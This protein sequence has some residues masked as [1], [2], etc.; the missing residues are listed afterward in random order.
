MSFIGE[1]GSVV[2]VSPMGDIQVIDSPENTFIVKDRTPFFFKVAGDLKDGQI[3]YGVYGPI[4]DSPEMYVGYTC[5]ITLR[6]DGSDWMK[7]EVSQ[8]NFIV[9]PSIVTR[10]HVYDFRNPEGLSMK[11]Y[12]K[13]LRFAE[14]SAC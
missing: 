5:N 6:T 8:A 10:N 4:I 14:V 9:G 3:L 13:M 1:L 7:E 2:K 12:P 11:G